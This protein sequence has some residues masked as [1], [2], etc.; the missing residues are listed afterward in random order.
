MGHFGQNL[1]GLN[2]D[3]NSDGE[4]SAHK[5]PIRTLSRSRVDT[6]HFRFWQR[7]RTYPRQ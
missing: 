1:K 5:V 7:M 6:I 3:K 2:A 4:D